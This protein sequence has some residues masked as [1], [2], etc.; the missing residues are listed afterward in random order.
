MVKDITPL[1][2][3]FTS[4]GATF[5]LLGDGTIAEP[6]MGFVVSNG[7]SSFTVELNAQLP[8][9]LTVAFDRVMALLN[10]AALSDQ[11]AEDGIMITHPLDQNSDPIYG[12]W[13]DYEHNPPGFLFE[14]GRLFSQSSLDDAIAYAID[15]NQRYIYS[16]HDQVSIS[17]TQSV[18]DCDTGQ[19]FTIA[20]FT[21]IGVS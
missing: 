17:I 10:V 18:I 13:L 8:D 19:D 2:R 11:L 6:S 16:L 9:R 15:H 7:R 21:K 3:R 1:I 4:I 12:L 5:L 20:E 14:S